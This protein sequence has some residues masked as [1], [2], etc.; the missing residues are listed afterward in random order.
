MYVRSLGLEN[1]N[2]VIASEQ[3]ASIQESL[4][5]NQA[6]AEAIEDILENVFAESVRNPLSKT[7]RGSPF[8]FNDKTHG[9]MAST[10]DHGCMPLK[11][12]I[13][14]L[15]FSFGVAEMTGRRAQMQDEVLMECNFDGI[16]GE[17]IFGIFDGH[18]GTH[19]SRFVGANFSPILQGC[20]RR[21]GRSDPMNNLRETFAE[22]DNL[23]RRYDIPHGSCAVVCYF[24]GSK[25][26]CAGLGDSRAVLCRGGS[27]DSAKAVLMADVLKPTDE[28]ERT[29]IQQLG[30]L[31]TE[32][33]RVAGVLGVSRALGDKIFQPFVS[34]VP[35]TKE[36]DLQDDDPFVIMGCDGVWDIF[37]DQ[38]AVDLLFDIKVSAPD[39]TNCDSWSLLQCPL[40]AIDSTNDLELTFPFAFCTF[41]PCLPT[42]NP[43]K[44][45]AVLRSTAYGEGSK[46]NISA[47]VIRLRP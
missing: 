18:G 32:N 36:F 2:P 14:G 9:T 47:L 12:T 24:V 25:V 4:C 5:R 46:D 8:L 44:A 38:Q 26:Y 3:Q 37:S 43:E 41:L 28:S 23:C 10:N 35:L 16:T 13:S 19:C 15:P 45:A 27:K 40:A 17:H 21:N 20:I 6:A 29:R 30:G 33:G 11:G 42:Q 1:N 7:M 34:A 22:L 39:H 31:V